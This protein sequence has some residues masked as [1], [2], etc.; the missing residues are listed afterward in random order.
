MISAKNSKLSVF[1]LKTQ[2]VF[3]TKCQKALA[4]CAKTLYNNR[5]DL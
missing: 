1:S 4:K 2:T 5:A 3:A